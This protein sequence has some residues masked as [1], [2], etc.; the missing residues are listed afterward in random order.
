MTANKRRSSRGSD[1]APSSAASVSLLCLSAC[2]SGRLC[3]KLVHYL[4]TTCAAC[5]AGS[6]LCAIVHSV[7]QPS[8]SPTLTAADGGSRLDA[9]PSWPW[10][11]NKQRP[12]RFKNKTSCG[13]VPRTPPD[14]GSD[15]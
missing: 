13:R 3:A 2:L 15:A 4:R 8:R 10:P 12:F 9:R 1:S 7:D 5:C 11:L 6:G 14:A